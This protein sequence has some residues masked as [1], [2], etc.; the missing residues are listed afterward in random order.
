MV[1]GL[2][3]RKEGDFF[4]TAG[5]SM[6]ETGLADGSVPHFPL[7]EAVMGRPSE[8]IREACSTDKSLGRGVYEGKPHMHTV[9]VDN[10]AQG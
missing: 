2:G 3:T 1:Y 9:A 6:G 7:L 8:R 5:K 4:P 10:K